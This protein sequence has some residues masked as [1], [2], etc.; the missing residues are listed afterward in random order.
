MITDLPRVDV[1]NTNFIKRIC[2]ELGFVCFKFIKSITHNDIPQIH[3]YYENAILQA[4]NHTIEYYDTFFANRHRTILHCK[5]YD[6]LSYNIESIW[7]SSFAILEYSNGEIFGIY[8]ISWKCYV[9]CE[10]CRNTVR[11][12]YGLPET[13]HYLLENYP[14]CSFIITKCYI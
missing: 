14:T 1:N 2:Y 9:I 7:Q 11:Y 12:I 8:G 10:P 3:T 4:S 5:G 13:L 6:E